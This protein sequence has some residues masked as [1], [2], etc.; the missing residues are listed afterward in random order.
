MA[1]AK[2]PVRG[3]GTVEELLTDRL[4][5]GKIASGKTV[6]AGQD[7]LT[8]LESDTDCKVVDIVTRN[9]YDRPNLLDEYGV[10]EP[11][12]PSSSPIVGPSITRE[13]HDQDYIRLDVG[14]HIGEERSDA[15]QTCLRMAQAAQRA[16]G[17]PVV[18]VCDPVG[19]AIDENTLRN[20]LG[21][22][23]HLWLVDNNLVARFGDKFT[24]WS[25]DAQI[26]FHSLPSRTEDQ[27]EVERVIRLQRDE[28][29]HVKGSYLGPTGNPILVG[30]PGNWE[31]RKVRFVDTESEF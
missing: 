16:I 3:S 20:L 21:G 18:I 7:I 27:R 24:F 25:P 28:K 30:R 31:K 5:T 6:T 9:L 22:D 19:N 29:E 2:E 12:N 17:V 10:T 11:D 26:V 23:E 1:Q 13:L 4:Y 14:D 8:L 15:V